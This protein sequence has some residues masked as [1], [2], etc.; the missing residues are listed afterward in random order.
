MS[1]LKTIKKMKNLMHCLFVFTII[2]IAVSAC[3]NAQL[4]DPVVKNF[5]NNFYQKNFDKAKA[6]S[7]EDFSKTIDLQI[8]IID[9]MPEKTV[10]IEN[11]NCIVNGSTS[12]CTFTI[13]NNSESIELTNIDG[14]WFVSNYPKINNLLFLEDALGEE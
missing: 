10:K 7:T 5:I 8:F 3:K 9:K 12:K 14:K 13:D 11:L 4:P 6:F 2:L 1:P